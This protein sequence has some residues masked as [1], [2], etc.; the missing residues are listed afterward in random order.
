MGQC[1]WK[2]PASVSMPLRVSQGLTSSGF[3]RRLVMKV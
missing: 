1:W 3:W 2:T